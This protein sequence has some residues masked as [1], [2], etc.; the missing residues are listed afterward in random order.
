[1]KP[2]H[3]RSVAAAV[4][5][6][7]LLPAGA[8]AAFP[9]DNGRLL[10]GGKFGDTGTKLFTVRLDGS[11]RALPVEGI[12]PD[13]S[14]DGG[15]VAFAARNETTHGL[16]IVRARLDGSRAVAL[17]DG[18]SIEPIADGELWGG[19]TWSPDGKKV[20]F[21]ADNPDPRTIGGDLFLI[22]RDGS[23][24]KRLTRTFA[25]EVDAAWSPDGRTIAY[26]RCD[27]GPW[28]GPDSQLWLLTV[29]SS[30][31]GRLVVSN[32]NHPDW[33]PD[34]KRIVYE[35]QR[36]PQN[37]QRKL[38]VYDLESGTATIIYQRLAP[39]SNPVWSPNGR[40]IAVTISPPTEE[41]QDPEIY[42]MRPNGSDIRRITNNRRNE[43]LFDWIA[44]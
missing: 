41:D 44:R 8:E 18:K 13:V 35:C 11:S 16:G 2:R 7:L 25:S 38:C 10:V 22:R 15:W 21:L 27:V 17:T 39:A 33:S 3:L 30:D 28:C 43:I 5:V 26:I 1:M 23:G 24:L 34:G 32:A 37:D 20:L 4:C 29:G 6:A 42:T 40:R 14:A 19:P 9:G 31:E 36:L 12:A